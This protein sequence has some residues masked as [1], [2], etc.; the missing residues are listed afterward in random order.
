MP[1]RLKDRCHIYPLACSRNKTKSWMSWGNSYTGADWITYHKTKPVSSLTVNLLSP[2]PVTTVFLGSKVVGLKKTWI[3]YV[4][5][6]SL[7]SHYLWRL[8]MTRKQ[9]EIWSQH[10]NHSEDQRFSKNDVLWSLPEKA[11]GASEQRQYR[12]FGTESKP[13][14]DQISLP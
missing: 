11:N 10:M 3:I 14:I 2:S 4:I 5:A 1:S 8:N 6:V 9:K 12:S 7:M 13:C